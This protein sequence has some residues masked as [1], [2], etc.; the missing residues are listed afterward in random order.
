[1]KRLYENV[2]IKKQKILKHRNRKT[3]KWIPL[4]RRRGKGH[5]VV[6]WN[7]GLNNYAVNKL[8]DYLLIQVEL[9]PLWCSRSQK[10]PVGVLSSLPRLFSSDCYQRDLE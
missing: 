8:K 3:T 5:L 2:K 10:R 6:R 9:L 4:N 7:D 1:M